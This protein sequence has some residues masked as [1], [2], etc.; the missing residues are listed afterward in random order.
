MFRKSFTS[1]RLS[2]IEQLRYYSKWLL[3]QY[4]TSELSAWF[5]AQFNHLMRI[6][7][8]QEDG[9]KL[10]KCDSLILLRLE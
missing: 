7:N 5:P 8:H 1:Y 4:R 6:I 9:K 3:S 2:Q 10:A